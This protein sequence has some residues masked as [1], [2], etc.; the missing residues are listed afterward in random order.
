MARL[1]KKVGGHIV[2]DRI[3]PHAFDG[4]CAFCNKP[5]E[6]RPYGPNNGSICYDCAMKD[7]ATTARMFEQMIRG[8]A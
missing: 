5:D 6:L 4:I 7:E 8:Q 2:M 3:D 1:F